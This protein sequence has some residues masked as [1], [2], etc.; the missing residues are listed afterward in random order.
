MHLA[1]V[2]AA[3]AR[4]SHRV[5]RIAFGRTSFSAVSLSETR[6]TFVYTRPS[7]LAFAKIVVSATPDGPF[8]WTTHTAPLGVVPAS[9]RSM[10]GR[11]RSLLTPT[12]T[13][14]HPV[15][16]LPVETCGVL[17]FTCDASS[18]SSTDK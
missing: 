4:A 1:R 12:N 17:S 11:S 2:S 7:A 18:P 5:H 15:A 13:T 3:H 16:R 8:G 6:A 14:S 9:A 10:R